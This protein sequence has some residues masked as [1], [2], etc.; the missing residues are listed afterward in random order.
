MQSVK[1]AAPPKINLATRGKASLPKA[2]ELLGD[3]AVREATDY[4]RLRAWHALR[5]HTLQARSARTGLLGAAEEWQTWQLG[6]G[7]EFYVKPSTNDKRW[8][9]PVDAVEENEAVKNCT[10]SASSVDQFL[11]LNLRRWRR[12]DAIPP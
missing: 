4:R 9:R 3:R 12:R 6:D 10:D 11:K 7:R 8:I 1:L 2:R 5:S